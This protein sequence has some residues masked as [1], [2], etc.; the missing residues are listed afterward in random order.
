MGVNVKCASCHNSFVS[1]LTLE[2]AY[3]FAS[4]FAEAPMELNRCDVPIG[5]IAQPNFL[6]KELGSVAADSLRER[7]LKLSEII[8]KPENGRLYR[9]VSNRIWKILLGRGIVEPPDE[10][11]NPPWDSDLLDW[12]AADFIDSD[13]DLKY[14]IKTIMTSKVY[15]LESVK[16]EKLQHVK[17]SSYVFK[18]PI[19]KRLS[20]EQFSDAVSQIISPVY[21]A[22][23]YDPQS[24]GLS[25]NR[26][27]HRE[28]KFDRDV[29]PEPGDRYFRYEFDVSDKSIVSAIGLISVD[30][31]YRLYINEKL[32]SE[33]IDWRKVDRMDLTSFLKK[34]KNIIA[35]KANNEGDIANPAG[36][37]LAI[38]I[39]NEDDSE[40]IIE[41]SRGKGWKSSDKAPSKEWR[42]LEYDDTV[43]S[44]VKNYG[45]KHWDD[46]VAYKF[47]SNN[48]KYARASL[49]RQHPFMQALGRPSRENVATSRDDQ[50]TLLQALELTNGAFFNNVLEEGAEEWLVNY[51]NN[52]EEIVNELYLKT[53]GRAPSSKEE[54]IM[55]SAL[56]N[57]PKVENVQDL[58]WAILL[59]P[60]FQYIY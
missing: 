5:K 21:Y 45:S 1:N 19:V 22:S 8:V 15:Q 25:S 2:Q 39:V 11:D 59:S 33:G 4:I 29:L 24:E 7:L 6:Y 41:S 36:I 49:V 27:W 58:F 20:A 32:V 51:R 38:K 13:Y 53:L 44:V 48:D 55:L 10:M 14:L 57:T 47:N 30:H 17:S 3:G 26:F 18:G 23:A 28:Q 40:T 60:E 52:P 16:Y 46:L 12:V 37:L 35:I 9:T 56:G 31:S 42:N 34:G 54:R 50:A 43:W